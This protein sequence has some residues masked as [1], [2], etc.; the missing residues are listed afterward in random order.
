MLGPMPDSLERFV[1]AQDSVYEAVRSE[2]AAGRKLTHW[3]WFVFPQLRGLGRSPMAQHFG[4]SGQAEAVAYWNHPVL[5]ERLR[6]CID[7]LLAIPDRSAR[8]ILGSPDDL[9]L[10][11][12]L[13]LFEAVAPDM[14]RFGRALDRFYGGQRDPLTLEILEGSE[15]V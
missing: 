1:Q 10:R 11:S 15:R 2:L 14:P 8:D 5:G 6:E 4:L 13:T 7:L 12:C 3:M 9:K